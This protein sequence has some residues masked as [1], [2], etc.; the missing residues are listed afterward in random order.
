VGFHKNNLP[1]QIVVINEYETVK[2]G[3]EPAF[4]LFG[5]LKIHCVIISKPEKCFK[6]CLFLKKGYSIL[7][8]KINRT[9]YEKHKFTFRFLPDADDRDNL[10]FLRQ[11]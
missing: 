4:G 9:I 8:Y 10:L 7:N 11:R 3:Y 5:I 1:E 2:I 6:F